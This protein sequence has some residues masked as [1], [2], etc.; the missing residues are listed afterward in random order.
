MLSRNWRSCSL[1]NPTVEKLLYGPG[2]TTSTE[3][4]PAAFALTTMPAWPVLGNTSEQLSRSAAS[5][6]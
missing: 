1:V 4:T 6:A 2:D 3:H 5:V